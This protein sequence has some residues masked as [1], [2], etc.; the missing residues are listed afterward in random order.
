MYDQSH[1][2]SSKCLD[3]VAFS[4]FKA[5]VP[6][7]YNKIFFAYSHEGNFKAMEGLICNELRVTWHEL[8]SFN[9]LVEDHWYNWNVTCFKLKNQLAPLYYEMDNRKWCY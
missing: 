1:W 5:L 4:A 6:I 9:V 2:V 8:R 7:D 3:F